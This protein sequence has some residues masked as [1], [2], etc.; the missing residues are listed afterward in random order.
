VVFFGFVDTLA[1]PWMP[2]AV[3]ILREPVVTTTQQ[4][5]GPQV[6]SRQ[7]RVTTST[8]P[9]IGYVVEE[10]LTG[11]TILHATTR[12]VIYLEKSAVVNRYTCH[13]EGAQLR[14]KMPLLGR[15]LGHAYRSPNSNCDEI[16]DKLAHLPENQGAQAQAV[17][18]AT[19]TGSE[20]AT[21]PGTG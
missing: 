17:T 10:S 11:Y 14:G 12:Y 2:A 18:G 1:T 3:F 9:V 21:T 16:A 13:Q 19:S 20:A 4:D 7:T 15:I 6:A 5:G 8:A